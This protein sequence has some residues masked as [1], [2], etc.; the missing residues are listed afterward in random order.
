MKSTSLLAGATAILMFAGPACSSEPT[1]PTDAEIAHIAYTAGVLDIEAG[2]QALAK[3]RTPAIRE[4]A[5]TMV[6]DHEAV[7][8]Q[9]LALLEKLGVT[10]QPNAT[11]EAL[12]AQAKKD[13]ERLGQLQGAD[14]ERGYIGNEAAFHAT[15]NTALETT[16]IPQ[17]DNA[18]LKSLLETGLALFRAHQG[19]AE[20][21][22][23]QARQ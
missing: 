14:F 12:T 23:A 7:N 19:H 15:V 17:S 3:A 18:E 4:F 11:S 13:R 10:P 21:L 1:N 2:K 8:N 16:L 9:A 20:Q 6:R 5:E 22:A